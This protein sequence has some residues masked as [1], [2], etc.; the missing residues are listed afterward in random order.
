MFLCVL[1][2]WTVGVYVADLSVKGR[3]GA[4]RRD[5]VR[6]GERREGETG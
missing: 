5:G 6:E 4:G 3:G 1:F 2:S